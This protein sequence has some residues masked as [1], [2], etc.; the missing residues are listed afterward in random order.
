MLSLS[1]HVHP[2]AMLFA[3]GAFIIIASNVYLCDLDP[4][5]ACHF[6]D[7]FSRLA[8]YESSPD[9][10][11]MWHRRG[12]TT[13]HS[14]NSVLDCFFGCQKRI[15]QYI[16]KRKVKHGEVYTIFMTP[17]GGF[18]VAFMLRKWFD[19]ILFK[20]L[21]MRCKLEKKIFFFRKRLKL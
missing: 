16:A 11:S 12:F 9:G 8:G 18:C 10:T 14:R 19:L 21:P 20:P 5:D 2:Y 13:H 17:D 4:T 7:S 3:I 15:R 1:I 6:D